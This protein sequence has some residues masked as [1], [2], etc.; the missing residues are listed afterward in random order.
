MKFK[1]FL[2]CKE[3]GH[4]CDKAQYK[5]ATYWDKFLLTIHNVFC[6][7][8]REHTSKNVKLTKKIN[9][10]HLKTLSAQEKE[11]LKNKLQQHTAQ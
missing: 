7:L 10:S 11:E 6:K 9:D 1:L 4:T 3:A 8:C 5:E 2:N